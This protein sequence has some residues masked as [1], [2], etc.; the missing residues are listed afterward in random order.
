MFDHKCGPMQDPGAGGPSPF[1]LGEFDAND[2]L[3]YAASL[4]RAGGLHPVFP[5]LS[6]TPYQLSPPRPHD[7]SGATGPMMPLDGYASSNASRPSSTSL[8]AQLTAAAQQLGGGADTKVASRNTAS[9]VVGGHGFVDDDGVAHCDAPM[10]MPTSR[11]ASP[12]PGARIDEPARSPIGAQRNVADT[13]GQ[14][15]PMSALRRGPTWDGFFSNFLLVLSHA[16]CGC[17]GGSRCLVPHCDQFRRLFEHVQE[18]R[19]ANC[20]ASQRGAGERGRGACPR[21]RISRLSVNAF[22]LR[23][24]GK[25][26][27]SRSSC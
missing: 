4:D 10:S 8:E 7:N 26:A 19:A 9:S 12:L 15:P 18:C 3:E 25:S 16:S 21:H 14:Q 17:S 24:S 13:I 20:E 22:L 6:P 5:P 23:S 11:C 27:S 1:R 2:A